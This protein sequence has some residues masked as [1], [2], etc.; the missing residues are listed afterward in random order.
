MVRHNIETR[1]TTAVKPPKDPRNPG[2]RCGG[3]FQ[4]RLR[5][6]A[7][8]GERVSW[9]GQPDA[10]FRHPAING[11]AGPNGSPPRC[12]RAGNTTRSW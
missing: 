11:D 12:A 1:P 2:A 10:D 3:H 8:Q 6:V 7:G 4:E 5:E 9:K